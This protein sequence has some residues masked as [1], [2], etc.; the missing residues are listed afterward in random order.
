MQGGKISFKMSNTPQSYLEL[1]ENQSSPSE[2]E[3]HDKNC[4]KKVPAWTLV[5]A[6]FRRR[7][8]MERTPT[9]LQENGN[10]TAFAMV[11]DFDDSAQ[12]VIRATSALDQGFWTRKVGR[13]TIHFSAET[14]NTDILIRTINSSNQVTTY[15]AVASW[16]DKLTQLIPNQSH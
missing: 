13:C 1:I 9:N 11:D 2:I 14:S 5:T 7:S 12:P 16:C 6:R 15:G 3:Y 4:T 8:G 10:I